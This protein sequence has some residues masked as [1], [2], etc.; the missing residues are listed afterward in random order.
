MKQNF[1]KKLNLDKI[2]L[3]KMVDSEMTNGDIA[4]YFKCSKSAIERNIK[5]FGII[6]KKRNIDNVPEKRICWKCKQEKL[7]TNDFFSNDNIDVFGFQKAC[8][9]CQSQIG[10]KYRENNVEYFK[11]KNKENYK[12]ENNKKRYEKYKESY[13]K[14]NFQNR[15]TIRGRL[16]SLLSAAQSRARKN[17]LD[18]NIDLNF[19]LSLYEKQNGKC[20]L[21]NLEFTF[22][23]KG[24]ETNYN[25]FNPS[26]DK[27]DHSKGYTKDNV[28]L[29]CTIVNLALNTFGEENFALMCQAYINHSKNTN[30]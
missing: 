17:N 29:V 7:L 3:E 1:M 15:K 16:Y 2:E 27:I 24:V 18:I 28:R 30:I 21:T 14:R 26:I 4:A 19:L 22:E 12:K 10:K 5:K 20:K 23:P 25:P 6:R 9:I 11:K 13:L 8:K